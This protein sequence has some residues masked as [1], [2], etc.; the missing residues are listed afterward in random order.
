MLVRDTGGARPRVI[1]NL[2]KAVE[3]NPN[4]AE[5][6]FLLGV[7]A[8]GDGRHEEAVEYLRRATAILPRQANFWH[9][10]I[11][12]TRWR[13]PTIRRDGGNW[14]GGRRGGRWRRPARGRRGKWPRRRSR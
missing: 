7:M 13:W 3:L 6:N 8:S 12:G 4:Y 14:P 5:A 10:P 2:K 9:G 11:S 1:E